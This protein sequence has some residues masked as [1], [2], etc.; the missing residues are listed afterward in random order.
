[1]KAYR[2]I[3]LVAIAMMMFALAACGSP[4][5]EDAETKQPD[6]VATETT[7]PTTTQ[8]AS[9]SSDSGKKDDKWKNVDYAVAA[10]KLNITEAKLKE[11]L[12]VS[13]TPQ[14]AG[15][16]IEKRPRMKVKKAAQ[17]LGVSEAKLRDALG[18]KPKAEGGKKGDGE[19]HHSK[20]H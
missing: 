12:E 17:T 19:E 16:N 5:Q 1:M 15:E 7:V 3:S 6:A 9:K 2:Q 8:D 14:E 11:A 20:N 13:Q 4:K 18:L 10:K